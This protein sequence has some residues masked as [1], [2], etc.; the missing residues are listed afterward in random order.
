[1]PEFST[2]KMSCFAGGGHQTNEEKRK[3]EDYK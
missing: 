1:M 3:G 2:F